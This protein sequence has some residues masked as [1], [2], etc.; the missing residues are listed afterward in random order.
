MIKLSSDP[1]MHEFDIR[2]QFFSVDYV[3]SDL[4]LYCLKY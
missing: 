1:P 4:E 2:P 3:S